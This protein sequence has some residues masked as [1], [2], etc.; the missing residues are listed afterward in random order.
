MR[1]EDYDFFKENGY[2]PLGR[3]LRDDEVARFVEA[4]DRDRR[5]YG[6]YWNENGIWQTQNCN[7]L[8]TAPQFDEIIR[9]PEAMESLRV[10]MGGEV[11]FSEVCLRHMGPYEGEPIAAMRSWEGPVGRRWHRDG[12]TRLMWAGTPAEPRL[13]PDDGLPVRRER[14]H[15]Q[16]RRFAPIDRPGNAGYRGPTR[17]RRSPRTPRL[18]W[19]GDTVRCHSITHGYR[20]P[21]EVRTQNRADLLRPPAPRL[22]QRGFVHT[23][24]IVAGPS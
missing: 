7:A 5:D 16:L 10:L 6:R 14:H 15:P 13:R 24:S 20:A 22:P 21:D 17:T 19:H 11:C 12:G 18:C 2:L 4:F 9:H 1:Q 3:I 23:H 8:L